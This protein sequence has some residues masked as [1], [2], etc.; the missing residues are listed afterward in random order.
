MAAAPGK[1]GGTHLGNIHVEFLDAETRTGNNMELVHRMREDIGLIAGAEVKVEKQ[2]EC[3]HT[4]PPVSIEISG[5]DFEVLAG[6]AVAITD[7]IRR[8]G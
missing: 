1:G 2:E 3:P 7:V 6:L 4:G 8:H 5:E